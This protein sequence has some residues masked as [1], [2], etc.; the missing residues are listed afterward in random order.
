MD[1]YDTR[2][3]KIIM[4]LNLGKKWAVAWDASE[5]TKGRTAE[6]IQERHINCNNN[7]YNRLCRI[8]PG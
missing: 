4:I 8:Y 6:A 1:R 5:Y 2:P 3:T 7:P